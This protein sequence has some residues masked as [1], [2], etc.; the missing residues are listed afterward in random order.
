MKLRIRGDSVRL[1]LTQSEVTALVERGAVEET[2]P[3]GADRLTYAVVADLPSG[4]PLQAALRSAPHTTRIE[5]HVASDVA[6]AW[7]TSETV[8]L[9]GANETLRVLVEKDFACLKDRPGEDDTDAF[10]NPNASC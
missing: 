3:F 9:E 1:R 7:A 5:I 2:T 4:S 6:R 10:P 8:G